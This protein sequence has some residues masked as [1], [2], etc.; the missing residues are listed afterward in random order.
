MR[1]R[2]CLYPT[3]TALVSFVGNYFLG[4]EEKWFQPLVDIQSPLLE[5]FESSTQVLQDTFDNPENMEDANHHTHKAL[6]TER[7]MS[8]SMQPTSTSLFKNKNG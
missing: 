3:K 1:V 6:P 8:T 2:E 7:T 4:K 5:Q